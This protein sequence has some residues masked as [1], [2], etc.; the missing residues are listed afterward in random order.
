MGGV[1]QLDAAPFLVFTLA[2][3][4]TGGSMS[5]IDAYIDAAS[6]LIGLEIAEAHQLGVRNFLIVARQMAELLDGAPL[7]DD[8]LALAPV[9]SPPER[10]A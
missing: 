1:T 8:E 7:E 5:D 10:Q 9:Y 3:C 4:Q 2:Q 6:A